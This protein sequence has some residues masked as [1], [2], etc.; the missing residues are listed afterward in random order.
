MNAHTFLA[1]L[2]KAHRAWLI[3]P[4]NLIRGMLPSMREI[5]QR[6]FTLV[7]DGESVAVL[8]ATNT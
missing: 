1:A 6:R 5:V 7:E 8:L 3:G 2:D 4:E